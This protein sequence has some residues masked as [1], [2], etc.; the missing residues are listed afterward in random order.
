[1]IDFPKI[2]ID[3]NDVATPKYFIDETLLVEYFVREAK[4]AKDKEYYEYSNFFRDC[5]S[6]VAALQRNIKY[7]FEGSYNKSN[8]DLSCFYAKFINDDTKFYY[9]DLI[10]IEKAIIQAEQK[11][12]TTNNTQQIQL[13]QDVL[14]WLQ[15]KGFIESA[16][17][18]PFRWL[19]TK[20]LARELL[21]HPKIKG[22]LKVAEVE[23]QTP[24]I[25]I[26]HGKLLKLAKDKPIPSSDSDKLSNY[27]STL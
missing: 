10:K 22:N 5:K 26:Y 21:T 7:Q 8:Q 17:T 23:R 2:I 24:T 6:R 16:A 18:K 14:R 11:L 12:I 25:F 4:K 19:K 1:M 20:Q 15:E 3:G 9:S 27:L 13:S